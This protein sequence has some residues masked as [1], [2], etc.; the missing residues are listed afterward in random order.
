[1]L[2][3][4]EKSLR[5]G[6]CL[7]IYGY[8]KGNNKYMKNYYKNKEL[9]YLQYWDVNSLYGWAMSQKLLVNNFE[10]IKDTSQFNEDFIKNYN[11]ESDEGYF[12]EVDVQYL[13]KL[14]ELHNDLPFLPERMKIEKVKKLVAN[15]HDK[16]E[17]VIH[18][19]NLKHTLNHILVLKKVHGVINFNENAWLKP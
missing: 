5:G 9:S 16:T 11:E 14:H 17:Y 1:M 12:L 7:S 18:I 15:L 3:M 8:V 6:I 4:V 19:R 13:E 2:L 10:W